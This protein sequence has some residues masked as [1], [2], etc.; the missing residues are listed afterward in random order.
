MD[1]RAYYT[2][3][4]AKKSASL[5]CP[6]CHTSNEYELR[7]MVRKKKDRLPPGADERDRARFAK[8]QSYMVL[9]DDKADCKNIRCRKR[10]DISGIKTMAFL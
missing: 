4:P 6:Y 10:F 3:S 9:L 8:S 5:N 7:W 1:E 2:E